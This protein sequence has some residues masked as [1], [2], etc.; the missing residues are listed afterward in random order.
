MACRLLGYESAGEGATSSGF[1]DLRGLTIPRYAWRST[2]KDLLPVICLGPLIHLVHA[3][4]APGKNLDDDGAILESP[5]L[6]SEG[7]P[8]GAYSADS[9]GPV[10]PL[11]LGLWCHGLFWMG[12]F[13]NVFKAVMP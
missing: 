3:G 1:F 8:S 12:F 5:L 7:V 6:L 2:R 4:L 9:L 10:L 11:M 13:A